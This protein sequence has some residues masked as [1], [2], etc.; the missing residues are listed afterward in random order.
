MR[1]LITFAW[2]IPLS[3]DFSNDEVWKNTSSGSV[4]KRKYDYLKSTSF[5]KNAAHILVNNSAVIWFFKISHHKKQ[6]AATSFK[7]VTRILLEK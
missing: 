3:S 5:Y 6:I 2:T 7:R 4:E 1:I